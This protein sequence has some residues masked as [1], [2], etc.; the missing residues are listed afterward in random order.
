MNRELKKKL[1]TAAKKARKNAYV[2]YSNFPIG[3]AVLTVENKIFSGCNIENAAYGLTNCAERTAIYKAIS[4]GY[5]KFKAL[6]VIAN[7][8]KPV[9]P[10]GSCRQV[11]SEF[12]DDIK[13][14]MVNT[15]GDEE[16]KSSGELLPFSFGKEDIEVEA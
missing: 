2:P 13:V 9:T 6:V 8:E 4:E 15:N 3:A 1:I 5:C 12:G 11:L 14:I 16:I 10:C 7:T